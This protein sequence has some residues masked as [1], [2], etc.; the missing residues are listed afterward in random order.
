MKEFWCNSPKL[1]VT[2][3]VLTALLLCVIFFL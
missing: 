3:I 1:T 2:F